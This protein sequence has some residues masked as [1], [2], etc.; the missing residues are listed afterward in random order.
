MTKKR[1]K[2]RTAHLHGYEFD[3]RWN[4]DTHQWEGFLTWY[5]DSKPMI[6]ITAV[7]GGLVNLVRICQDAL[8]RAQADLEFEKLLLPDMG[9]FQI[10]YHQDW[11][12]LLA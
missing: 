2:A 11:K 1:T 3:A 4:G 7:H 10:R 8:A 5:M 9:D 6:T 12:Q